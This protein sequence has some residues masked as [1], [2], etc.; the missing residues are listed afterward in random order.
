MREVK[1][2]RDPDLVDLALWAF[3]CGVAAVGGAMAPALRIARRISG[4]VLPA[5]A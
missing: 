2:T 1:K 4:R 5:R 3:V